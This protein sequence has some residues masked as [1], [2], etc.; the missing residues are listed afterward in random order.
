MAGEGAAD[1]GCAAV[2]DAAGGVADAVGG[3]W[4][5]GADW[6]KPTEGTS[7]A[8]RATPRTKIET[9]IVTLL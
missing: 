2:D 1:T 8:A 5:V 4:A 7:K 6:A 9:N 3:S